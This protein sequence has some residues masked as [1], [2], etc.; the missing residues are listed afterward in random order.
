MGGVGF[1]FGDDPLQVQRFAAGVNRQ[2]GKIAAPGGRP[3]MMDHRGRPGRED[4]AVSIS[5][6]QQE[7]RDRYLAAL[8][9]A[10]VRLQ[11]GPDPEVALEALIEA[12][13]LL[14]AHLRHELDKLRQEQAE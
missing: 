9:D 6:V 2:G 12:C 1:G 3:G 5:R 14:Q 4:A 8:L 7:L 13:D 10:A 11:Q